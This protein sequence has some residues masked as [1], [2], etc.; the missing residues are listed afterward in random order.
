[1]LCVVSY[2][3]SLTAAQSKKRV[4]FADEVEASFSND[5]VLRLT[6]FFEE[7]HTPQDIRVHDWEVFGEN[8][9]ERRHVKMNMQCELFSQFLSCLTHPESENLLY[10]VLNTVFARRKLSYACLIERLVSYGLS[11]GNKP[12]FLPARLLLFRKAIELGDESVTQLY[13]R[14]L[15]RIGSAEARDQAVALI[16]KHVEA[17]TSA[18]GANV[19]AQVFFE[20]EA[21]DR[22]CF[23]REEWALVQDMLKKYITTASCVDSDA[24]YY[25]GKIYFE[26]RGGKRDYARALSCFEKSEIDMR[27]Y[28]LA[29]MHYYGQGCERDER[30]AR[31]YIESGLKVLRGEGREKLLRFRQALDGRRLWVNGLAASYGVR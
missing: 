12:D 1:M 28:Y 8:N 23:L 26:G 27:N 19:L 22:V 25:L 7:I 5:D 16:L 14:E 29:K 2:S 11:L 21:L 24:Y 4:R 10:V 9:L 3:L 18:E 13:V 6:T 30:K 17:S 31:F 20:K 15:L